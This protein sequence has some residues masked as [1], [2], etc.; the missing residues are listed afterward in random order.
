LAS[1]DKHGFKVTE[2]KKFPVLESAGTREISLYQRNFLSH[3]TLNK[4]TVGTLTKLTEVGFFSM[5]QNGLS[6]CT[7]V[8]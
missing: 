1:C 6:S 5:K 7:Q 4:N 2:T 8:I 3:D